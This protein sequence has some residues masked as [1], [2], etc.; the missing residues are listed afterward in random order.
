MTET[1][2]SGPADLSGT[3][4]ER[5]AQLTSLEAGTEQLTAAWLRRQLRSALAAWANDE[6]EVDI[7]VETRT[8]Y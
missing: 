4:D 1:S 3:V 7:E 5:I 8:D 6:T 2:D